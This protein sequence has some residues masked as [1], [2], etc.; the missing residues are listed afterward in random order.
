MKVKV[1]DGL[2]WTTLPQIPG[3]MYL[4]LIQNY[5]FV[6]INL[7]WKDIDNARGKSHQR[8]IKKNLTKNDKKVVWI[9]GDFRNRGGHCQKNIMHE[10]GKLTTL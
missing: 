4:S 7:F 2:L 1:T 5:H 3:R 9:T 6:D 8:G 10:R